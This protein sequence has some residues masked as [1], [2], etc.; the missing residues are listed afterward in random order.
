MDDLPSIVD[1]PGGRVSDYRVADLAAHM[2]A[3]RLVPLKSRTLPDKNLMTARQILQK[4][5]RYFPLTQSS[6]MIFNLHRNLPWMASFIRRIMKDDMDKNDEIQC[7]Q[8]IFDFYTA[9][10][11]DEA[12]PFSNVSATSINR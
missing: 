3:H 9:A 11:K 2:K 5:L 4:S 10:T 1:G 12:L 6:T 8:N 7:Q